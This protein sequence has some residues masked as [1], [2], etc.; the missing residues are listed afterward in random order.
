[1]NIFFTADT[2]FGH[3]NIIRY[4]KRPWINW[5]TDV[6]KVFD[7]G[8]EAHVER[9]ASPEI[10]QRRKKEMDD[11]LVCNW[12]NAVKPGDLV[13][14]VGDFCFGK[15]PDFLRYF[16][17]LNGKIVLIKGNHDKVAWENRSVFHEAHDSYLEVEING[18][19]ITLC[20]YAL[21]VW[22]KSHL[23][24]WHLYGHSHGELA[25]LKTSRSFDVGVDCHNFR[26]ISFDEV[27]TIMIKKNFRPIFGGQ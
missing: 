17:A 11:V 19:E 1:M 10:A 5:K 9:W 26:P 18:K 2:H 3:A 27:E 8:T 24:S 25:D 23:G 12:N 22:N 21:R 16:H 13:Y 4:S 7:P 15:T 14:H 20:H 6:V